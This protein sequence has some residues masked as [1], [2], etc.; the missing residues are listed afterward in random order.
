[1]ED[2]YVK[3]GRQNVLHVLAYVFIVNDIKEYWP[4][5]RYFATPSSSEPISHCDRSQSTWCNLT[6]DLHL[7]VIFVIFHL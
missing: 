7:Y 2:T 1:M 6:E 4:T 3:K 5:F